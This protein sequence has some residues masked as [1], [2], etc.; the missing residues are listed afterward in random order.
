M[1]AEAQAPLV[2]V[3]EMEHM[4]LADKMQVVFAPAQEAVRRTAS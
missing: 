1:A 2:V 4:E 3:H